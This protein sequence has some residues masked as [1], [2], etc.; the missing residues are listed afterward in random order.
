MRNLSTHVLHFYVLLQRPP[1]AEDLLSD[2]ELT[3]SLSSPGALQLRVRP[4]QI[5]EEA[6]ASWRHMGAFPSAQADVSHGQHI[7]RGAV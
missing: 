5:S 1:P 2:A 3:H 4:E 7:Q 6:A